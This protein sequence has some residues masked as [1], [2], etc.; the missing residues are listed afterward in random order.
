MGVI[1]QAQGDL[2]GALKVYKAERSIMEQLVEGPTNTYW[3]R[4]L[5]VSLSKVG[6]ILQAQ[7]DLTGALADYQA[8]LAI[9]K[10][11]TALDPGKAKWKKEQS[12]CQGKVDALLKLEV[13]P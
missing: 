9:M 11:L 7:G 12:L 10:K 4:D 2:A 13:K 6:N 1:L 5:S 8:A 3:Q